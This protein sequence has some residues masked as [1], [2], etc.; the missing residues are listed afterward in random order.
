MAETNIEKRYILFP[1]EYRYEL[2]RYFPLVIE[3]V[4]YLIGIDRFQS[5]RRRVDV[6]LW[7]DH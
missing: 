3:E 1:H 4:C 7:F 2:A 6:R 5:V